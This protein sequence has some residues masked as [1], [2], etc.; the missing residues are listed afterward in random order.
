MSYD[1]LLIRRKDDGKATVGDLHIAPGPMFQCYTLENT[2]ADNK[3]GVSCIP[4]GK[5]KLRVREE[6]GFY[7]QYTE[8][9]D[10][11]KGMV[12]VE[13]KGRTFILF[14]IGNTHEDTK[15][16]ILPGLTQYKHADGSIAVG[17]S[18][19]AY[20]AIYS[21]ILDAAMSSGH[22]HVIPAPEAMT[23]ADK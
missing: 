10:W 18:T 4:P 7:S 12:E 3:P 9:F 17:K 1:L 20:R 13:V 22:L 15:G 6:G 19:V 16:C 11:H 14:H 2:W 8:R 5:H 23:D 21:L